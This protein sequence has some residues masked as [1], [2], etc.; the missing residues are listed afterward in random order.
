MF[1]AARSAAADAT[2]Q[3]CGA[4]LRAHRCSLHEERAW[5]LLLLKERFLFLAP[6]PPPQ[7]AP[8]QTSGGAPGPRPLGPRAGWRS[9]P[10]RLAALLAEAR[11]SARS[12]ARSC[13]RAGATDRDDSYLADEVVRKALAEEYSRAAA[14]LAS[15]GLAPLT[16][17]TADQLQALLQ[18]H[19]VPALAA[20][21]RPAGEGPNLFFRKDSKQTLRA[22]PKGSGAA[23]GGGRWEHWRVVL[24]SPSSAL[25]AFHEVL[26][27][28]ASGQVPEIIAAA[29]SLSKLTPLRKAG[30]G[31]RPI[32]APNLL[33][34]VAG[35]LLVRGGKKELVKALG[36]RQF[37]IGTAAGTELLAHTVRALTEDDP[38][39]VVTA[40]DVR[41]AYCTASRA[42]CLGALAETAPELLPCAE[43]FADAN[44]N[45]CSGMVQAAATRFAQ[46]TA[47]TRATR[48]PPCSSLA[49]SPLAARNSRR[50]CKNG[51][52]NSAFTFGGLGCLLSSTMW[53]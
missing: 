34:R 42:A 20:A 15:P 31:V 5:K 51:R 21:P 22:T 45:T 14:L 35:R 38:Q 43:L 24:A 40:L 41:N 10:R 32:A 7:R 27:K 18:P 37:A 6:P 12:L 3:L 13:E 50:P 46:R 49:A 47:W 52:A 25:T 4:V 44:P 19:A 53:R 1:R 26:L 39:L 11:A 28:V 23:L 16:P 30:S 29:L 8:P 9:A 36:R 17:E 2:E 33:R 48:S